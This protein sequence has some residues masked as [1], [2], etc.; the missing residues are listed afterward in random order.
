MEYKT[1]QKNIVL[2]FL[3]E[4]KGKCFLAKD[5]AKKL[6]DKV[7]TATLYRCLN[8]LSKKGVIKKFSSAD[9]EGS[10]FQFCGHEKCNHYHLKCVKC[11]KVI[12]VDCDF[13]EKA[14]RHFL[15]DHA[16]LMS[17]KDTII[18]C[19]CEKCIDLKK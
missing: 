14:K 18:Y 1:A 5:I 8:E 4:N 15:K 2:N 3:I 6:K 17:D 12:H 19:E 9:N 13:M 11:G 16:F 10:L 7:S